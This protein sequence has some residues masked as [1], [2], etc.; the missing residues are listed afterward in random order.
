MKKLNCK[1]VIFIDLDGTLRGDD[2]KVSPRNIAAIERVIENGYEV[3]LCTGRGF[4]QGLENFKAVKCR[5]MINCN[6]VI[7]DAEYDK[8]LNAESF[9]K[10]DIDGI[11]E[12]YKEAKR[13]TGTTDDMI[14]LSAV[15]NRR[16]AIVDGC[17]FDAHL[18]EHIQ[19]DG[20]FE[21]NEIKNFYMMIINSLKKEVLEVFAL[22]QLPKLD[23]FNK[24]FRLS[25]MNLNIGWYNDIKRGYI[26]I[27]PINKNKGYG[28]K[29]FCKK[30][31]IDIKDTIVMGDSYND[32]EMFKI[33]GRR[34]AMGNAINELKELATDV[35]DTNQNDGVGLFLEKLLL[36]EN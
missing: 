32:I 31:G 17:D 25:G 30:F 28:V 35:T 23:G 9:S 20:K 8:F 5:F 14:G 12:C 27:S 24:R 26:D 2:L 22:K 10:K 36:E 3:V 11:I 34:V 1:K 7:Y 21:E 18:M 33:A 6:F 29:A 15:N 16:T 4:D 13:I 19:V